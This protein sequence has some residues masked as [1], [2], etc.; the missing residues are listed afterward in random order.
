MHMNS[1]ELVIR[2]VLASLHLI[3]SKKKH[4]YVGLKFYMSH[5]MSNNKYAWSV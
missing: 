5:L 3:Y 1:F 2:A 4:L